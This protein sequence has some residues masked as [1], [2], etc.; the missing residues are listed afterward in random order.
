MHSWQALLLVGGSMGSRQIAKE[1]RHAQRVQAALVAQLEGQTT[2]IGAPRKPKVAVD[3]LFAE[4]LA[5]ILRMCATAL[6]PSLASHCS[7]LYG[8]VGTT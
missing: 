2:R 5:R 4:R 3:A 7:R 6:N 1:V 8:C